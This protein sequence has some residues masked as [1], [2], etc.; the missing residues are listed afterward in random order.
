[1][2]RFNLADYETVEERIK[3]FYAEHPDGRIVTKLIYEYAGDGPRTWVFKSSVYL[4][5]GDQ[6][7]KLPKATG[8]ASEVDGTGGANNGSAA[9]NAETSAIGRCLA[10]AGWSGNRRSSR[11]EMSKVNRIAETDW[12][13]QA[14]KLTDVGG[15]RW[16]Y[17][18]A[19]A[20]GA[21]ADVLERLADRARQLNPDGEGQGADGSVPASVPKAAKK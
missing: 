7:A 6:A 13:A 20:S 5:A 1:M 8:Y 9:E 10:N 17:S 11:E 21:P 3:R 18:Q 4:T 19:K 12:E 15:L 14:A 2:A 16:L